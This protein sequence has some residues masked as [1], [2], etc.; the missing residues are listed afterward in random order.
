RPKV[1]I[2]AVVTICPIAA[3]DGVYV[4][5]R[6]HI[7]TFTVN[8]C[9]GFGTYVS[10]QSGVKLWMVAVPK[11][12]TTFDRFA[13]V[14]V[15]MDQ[16]AIGKSNDDRWDW[17]AVLLKPGMTF[18]MRPNT[19]HVVYTLESSICQGGHF[20]ATSTLQDT[21]YGIMHTFVAGG[22]ITNTEHTQDAL[23]ILCRMIAFYHASFVRAEKDDDDDVK[24]KESPFHHLPNINKFEGLMDLLSLC[25]IA[26]LGNVLC[27]WSYKSTEGREQGNSLVGFLKITN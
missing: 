6:E 18:I 13:S 12:E 5:L 10:P 15:F 17:E 11:P 14:D 16:Y 7:T 1:T 4:L 23:R 8:S 20:Y 19:P 2:F 25:C 27:D 9:D 24:R 3:S 26:E 21:C 22:F